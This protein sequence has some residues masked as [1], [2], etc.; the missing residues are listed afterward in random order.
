MRSWIVGHSS[1]TKRSAGGS[2]AAVELRASVTGSGIHR[3]CVTS[4]KLHVRGK[5]AKE[6]VITVA[7]RTDSPDDNE[8][9][10]ESSFEI[11]AWSKD[12]NMLLTSQIQAQ[13][14][15]D[16]TTPI[17]FDFNTNKYWRVELYPLFKALIPSDCYVVYRV[18]R[19]NDK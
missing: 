2:S 9:V 10:R 4:W 8:W 17:V 19:F 12:G 16:E 6:Q 15:W 18:L 7:E 11:K 1:L 5:D 3:R 13:G 14:D